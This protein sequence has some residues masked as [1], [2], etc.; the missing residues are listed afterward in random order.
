MLPSVALPW[1]FH[2][3]PWSSPCMSS[4]NFYYVHSSLNIFTSSLTYPDHISHEGTITCSIS[5]PCKIPNIKIVIWVRLRKTNYTIT[6]L[7]PPSNMGIPNLQADMISANS[8]IKEKC[9]ANWLLHTTGPT[10]FI[11]YWVFL[12]SFYF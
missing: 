11:D 4:H 2:I 6:W 7:F 10:G 8:S 5:V 12:I 9:W 1:P 3:S